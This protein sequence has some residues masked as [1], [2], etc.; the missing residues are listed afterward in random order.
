MQKCFSICLVWLVLRVLTIH[1]PF[2]W[3]NDFPPAT[4]R[5]DS[6]GLL[7][8]LLN[9]RAPHALGI[10][11]QGLV[12]I[13]P[14]QPILWASV[15]TPLVGSNGG[16]SPWAQSWAPIS[17]DLWEICGNKIHHTRLSNHRYFIR[18]AISQ[19]FFA[20]IAD[21][22]RNSPHLYVHYNPDYIS[23]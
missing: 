11:V 17:M 19:L 22:M 21:V 5:V 14:V 4:G 12:L 18:R 20:C 6:K 3:Q 8:A 2:I 7:E 10:P 13:V 23:H 15:R 9:I 1:L 16:G